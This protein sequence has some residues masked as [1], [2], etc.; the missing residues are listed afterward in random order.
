MYHPNV[1]QSETKCF[2]LM[3][4]PLYSQVFRNDVI[5]TFQDKIAQIDPKTWFQVGDHAGNFLTFDDN[6][7]PLTR[8]NPETGESEEIPKAQTKKLS[9]ELAGQQKKH[10]AWLKKQAK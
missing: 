10:Q 8:K 3:R 5:I 7:L 1:C 6:G 9:K 4:S 2:T